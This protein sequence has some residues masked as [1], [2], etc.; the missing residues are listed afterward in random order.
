MEENK[1]IDKRIKQID[2]NVIAIGDLHGYRKFIWKKKYKKTK[3]YKKIYKLIK[4]K[5]YGRI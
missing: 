3:K 5:I 4:W 1:T 2:G